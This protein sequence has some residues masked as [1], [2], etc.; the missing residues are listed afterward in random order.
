MSNTEPTNVAVSP[1]DPWQQQE[2]EYE[3]IASELLIANK[4]ALFD[5]LATAGIRGLSSSGT[6]NLGK[7]K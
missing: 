2:R 3:R 1:S 5:A 7:P 6:E 4:T